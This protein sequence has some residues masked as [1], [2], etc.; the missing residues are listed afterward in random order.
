MVPVVEFRCARVAQRGITGSAIE[1][2]VLCEFVQ[3]SI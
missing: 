1:G 3:E 2:C